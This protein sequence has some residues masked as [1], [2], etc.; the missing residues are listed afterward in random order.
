MAKLKHPA[1]LML[2]TTLA[3]YEREGDNRL[4]AN[5]SKAAIAETIRIAIDWLE[6]EAEHAK[7]S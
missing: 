1:S 2:Y 6:K 3:C 7:D 4:N 5:I